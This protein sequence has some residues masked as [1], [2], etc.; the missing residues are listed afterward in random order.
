MRVLLTGVGAP[1]TRG[2][3]FALRHNSDRVRVHITGVDIKEDVVGRFWIENFHRV[4]SPED[5]NYVRAINRI[6]NY[7]S[8]DVVLPQTTRETAKLSKSYK[9]VKAKVVVSDASA[10]EKANNKYAL[11]K[12]CEEIGIP[13]PNS[14]LVSTA[15]ELRRMAKELGYPESPVVVKPPVSFG[16]RG[17]RVLRKGSS[18][19]T[20]RFLTQKPNVTELSLEELLAILARNDKTDFPELMISEFLPGDEYSVDVFSGE[21]ISVAIPRLRKEIVNGISFRTA[22][23]YRKDIVENSLKLA[24]AAGLRFAFGFQFKLDSE[25]VAKILECNPRVQGTMAASLFSGVNVIWMAVREAL[26]FPVERLPK[27]LKKA[28]FYR[29]W[30]GVG[31]TGKKAVEI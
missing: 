21:K 26:G 12:L 10:I 4:P 1:G 30:G 18:W 22:L 8:I 13:F 29:Y 9:D 31:F 2:T 24:R 14:K 27:P 7:D 5:E 23:E 16:S 11:L 3:I 28:E 19:D 17:F 15:E 25:G 20:E 6:C